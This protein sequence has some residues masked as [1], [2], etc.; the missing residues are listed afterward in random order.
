[1]ERGSGDL[2][3]GNHLPHGDAEAVHDS[4]DHCVS[5]EGAD[6]TPVQQRIL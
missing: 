4:A 1:M 2:Q 5:E 3:E 6:R